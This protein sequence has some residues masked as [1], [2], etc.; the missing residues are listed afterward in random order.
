MEMEMEMEMEIKY[1][2]KIF[3][4]IIILFG[5]LLLFNPNMKIIHMTKTKN[6]YYLLEGMTSQSTDPNNVIINQS[7]AFCENHRGKS[8][9]LEEECNKLTK[10]N[11][12]ATSC[13][14]WA[15]PG[16]CMAGG[17]GGPTFNTNKSGKT[18]NLDYYY[19]QNKCYGKKCK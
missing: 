3:V 5:F 19:Y 14:V 7:D 11:C 8:G 6:N 1:I 16:K 15:S 13:C 4:W 12:T 9:V 17:E 18:N 10:N 2:L